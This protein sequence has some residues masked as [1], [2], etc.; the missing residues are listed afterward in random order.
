[1]IILT[2]IHNTLD[3]P[4]TTKIYQD[5]VW[6]KHRLPRKIISDRGPQFINQFTKDLYQLVGI[7]TNPSMAYHPQ[8]DGQTEGMNQEIEQYLWLFINH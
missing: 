8:T 1:M 4:E 7:E 3:A 6:S 2:A 5:K